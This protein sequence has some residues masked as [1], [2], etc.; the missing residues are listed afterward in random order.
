MDGLCH[1]LFLSASAREKD[2]NLLFVRERLLKSRVDLAGLL[3]LYRQVWAGRRVAADD[4]N[5]LIDLL[6]LSGIAR[7]EGRRQKEKGKRKNDRPSTVLPFAFFLLPSAASLPEGSLTV[8]NR[9]YARVFDG[10]WVQRHMPDA[11]IRR[12]RAAYRRGARRAALVGGGVALVMLA[13]ALTALD[14]ARQARQNGHRAVRGEMRAR[15]LAKSLQSALT[16]AEAAR[17]QARGE[18]ARA[19]TAEGRERAQ[20]LLAVG[21]QAQAE[22]EQGRAEQQ[23]QI[24]VNQQAMAEQQRR[25]AVQQ[26]ERGRRQLVQLNVANGVRLMDEG[27]LFGALPW[28]A[29]AVKLEAG[30]PGAAVQRL[31][32]AAVLQQCPKPVQVWFHQGPINDAAFNAAGSRVVT[33]SADGTARVWD[34]MTGQAVTPPLRHH[35]AVLA[36]AFSAD[37]RRVV[38]AS[39]DGTARVWDAATGQPVTAPL[40]QRGAVRGAAFSADGRRVVTAGADGT[41]RVWDAGTGR[42]LAPPLRHRGPVNQ[43]AVQPGRPVGGD[44]QCGRDGPGVGRRDRAPARRAAAAR[45]PGEPGGVQPG[46]APGGHRQPGSHRACLGRGHRPVDHGPPFHS[47][48]VNQA[49]FSPDGLRVVTAC[50]DGNA[51]VW[52]AV[53]GK[54]L[55]PLL[56]HRGEVWSAAF[57]PDGRR[58]VTAS[59]DHTARVWDAATGQPLTPPLAHGG[60]VA[61][62]AFSPGGRRLLTASADGAARVWDRPPASRQ[63]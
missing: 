20:R 51:Q 10:A 50:Q 9:I 32:L 31:R 57:S 38:T 4:T 48:R 39:A 30:R 29:E 3:D 19:T 42:A 34:A 28:L 33:A 21:A 13:L 24:A 45:R 54:L 36:A 53:T 17:N 58:I 1:E 62:A 22:R 11:E 7:V 60:S 59:A 23:R 52:D 56:K 27:D 44:R 8:R 15:G 63:S 37:G 55:L 41:A 2:D 5:P 40:R 16:A 14:Q 47:D 43:A 61:A 49:V 18:A 6:R 35:G 46:R 12:Q 25:S 26:R